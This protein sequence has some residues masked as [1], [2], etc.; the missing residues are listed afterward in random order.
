MRA[1][2]LEEH[3]DIQQASSSFDD[4]GA[5][6]SRQRVDDEDQEER[7]DDQDE[8]RYDVLLVVFPDEED[9][10]LHRVDKPVE[11]GGRTTGETKRDGLSQFTHLQSV[12]ANCC[13]FYQFLC[14]FIQVMKISGAVM[15]LFLLVLL[16]FVQ[17]LG[18]FACS[19]HRV[20]LSLL[21]SH[22]LK[23]RLHLP[24]NENSLL[25]DVKNNIYN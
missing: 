8:Q 2:E 13:S 20:G 15:E 21:Q 12:R 11:A 22:Q 6:L 16:W 25:L 4:E 7:Q 5:D 18:L 10:G 9:E 3:E 17:R 14:Y 19:P 23:L 1:R 24:L